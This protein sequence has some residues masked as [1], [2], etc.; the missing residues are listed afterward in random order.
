MS[1]KAEAAHAAWFAQHSVDCAAHFVVGAK[2]YRAAWD[3]V[4]EGVVQRVSR[5]TISN[6]GSATES[7]SGN[8]PLYVAQFRHDWVEQTFAWR[9]FWSEA[10]AR[11]DLVRKLQG[12]IEE[13]RTEIQKL[14]KQIAVLTASD[15]GPLPIP[16]TP[17]P[18]PCAGSAS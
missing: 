14:E 1:A 11:K 2:A 12:R 4:E 6:N 9:F 3:Q 7:E 8:Y 18:S 16:L 5:C 10:D 13:N 15:V 17:H